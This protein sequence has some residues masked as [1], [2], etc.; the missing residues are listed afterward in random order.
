M[1]K[2]RQILERRRATK[3]PPLIPPKIKRFYFISKIFNLT[4]FSIQ[5][6]CIQIFRKPASF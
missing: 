3:A 1:V 6:G 5:K 4:E 2:L